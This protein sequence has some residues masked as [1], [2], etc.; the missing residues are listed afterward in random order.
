MKDQQ[1]ERVEK[2]LKDWQVVGN[3]NSGNNNQEKTAPTQQLEEFKMRL[4]IEVMMVVVVMMMMMT[5]VIDKI[6]NNDHDN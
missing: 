1:L 2:E 5:G 3:L 6:I 4:K